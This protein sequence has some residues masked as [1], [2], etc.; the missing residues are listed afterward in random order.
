VIH[1]FLISSSGFYT[2]QL[3]FNFNEAFFLISSL[4]LFCNKTSLCRY[5]IVVFFAHQGI[6]LLSYIKHV[7]A[8]CKRRASNKIW[9][10]S[11]DFFL[12]NLLAYHHSRMRV[13]WIGCF[14]G[15][16][17]PDAAACLLCNYMAIKMKPSHI[18]WA[19][20]VVCLEAMHNSQNTC[21]VSLGWPTC[22]ERRWSSIYTFSCQNESRYRENTSCER[23]GLFFW[24]CV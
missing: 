10:S 13:G 6:L 21:Y 19:S 9:L 1:W 20:A 14:A 7:M 17:W 18:Y 3:C 22:S 15:K 12:S 16:K 2:R 4:F 5:L 8:S 24:G 11:F 23:Q